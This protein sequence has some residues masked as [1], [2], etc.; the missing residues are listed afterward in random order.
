MGNGY[1][2]TC[3]KD[4]FTQRDMDTGTIIFLLCCCGVVPGLICLVSELSKP[5]NLCTICNTMTLPAQ[6]S[7]PPFSS[8]DS[9]EEKKVIENTQKNKFCEHCGAELS[10]G[11]KFC[12]G[13]GAEL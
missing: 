6:G 13:C 12:Q 2:P 1:C 4:V 7:S 5:E 8:T 3:G 10:P 11:Q 9:Y